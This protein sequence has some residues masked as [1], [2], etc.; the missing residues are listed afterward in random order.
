MRAVAADMPRYRD[1][2][3]A[4]VAT[5]RQKREGRPERMLGTASLPRSMIVDR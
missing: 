2:W 4:A 5:I 3:R 1:G